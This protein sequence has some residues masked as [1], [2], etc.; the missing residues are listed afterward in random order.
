M[1]ST[2]GIHEKCESVENAE[3]QEYKN[4]NMIVNVIAVRSEQ[5]NEAYQHN[6]SYLLDGI[7]L[8]NAVL[9]AIR[10][11]DNQSKK[12]KYRTKESAPRSIETLKCVEDGVYG[13]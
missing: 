10:D 7:V 2:V 4:I 5:C 13:N 3:V 9:E 6:Y 1:L 12:N 11:E 8:I